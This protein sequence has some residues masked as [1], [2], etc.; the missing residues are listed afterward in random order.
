MSDK[1]NKAVILHA[2]NSVDNFGVTSNEAVQT[3]AHAAIDALGRL[4]LEVQI[5]ANETAARRSADLANNYER[6]AQQLRA[7]RDGVCTHDDSCPLHTV[8]C[9]PS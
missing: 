3:A 8:N 2:V 7:I 4:S 9:P 5:D 6:T 1:L